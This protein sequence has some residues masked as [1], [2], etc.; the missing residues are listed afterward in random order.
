D[1]RRGVGRRVG[2]RPQDLAGMGARGDRGDKPS[3]APS[4]QREAGENIPQP[5]AASRPRLTHHI[6]TIQHKQ[7]E[8]HETHVTAESIA[9]LKDRLY[10]FVTIASAGFAVEHRGAHGT[11][12]HPKPAS[13]AIGART[14]IGSCRWLWPCASARS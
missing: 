10:P 11:D 7:I 2:A 8:G 12:K 3:E 14:S 1:H 5:L 6:L 4:W 13:S 9:L